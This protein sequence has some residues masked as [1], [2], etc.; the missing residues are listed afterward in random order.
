MSIIPERIPL[1]SSKYASGR[2]ERGDFVCVRANSDA[3]IETNRVQR[4]DHLQGVKMD[5]W[6]NE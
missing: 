1:S 5:G 2:L 6:M 4:I 3:R